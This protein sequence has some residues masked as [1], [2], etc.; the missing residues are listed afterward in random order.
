MA[1]LVSFGEQ[2]RRWRQTN[3]IY[4]SED[5]NS[6]IGMSRVRAGRDEG[7]LS[8]VVIAFDGDGRVQKITLLVGSRRVPGRA[9]MFVAVADAV[10]GICV[11][12]VD[13]L[14]PSGGVANGAPVVMVGVGCE[15]GSWALGLVS[16]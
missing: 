11:S 3:L 6:F 15:D 2:L 1:V 7:W 12:V 10:G 4:C 8:E 9:A 16:S 5:H 14:A 13:V